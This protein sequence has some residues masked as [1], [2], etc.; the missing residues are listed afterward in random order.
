MKKYEEAI[1]SLPQKGDLVFVKEE[2]ELFLGPEG[3]KDPGQAEQHVLKAAWLCLL[4][5]SKSAEF[6]PKVF[7]ALKTTDYSKLDLFQKA[8]IH[9]L[10]FCQYKDGFFDVQ[11]AEIDWNSGADN[12]NKTIR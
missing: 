2:L 12:W 6:G 5:W 8:V 3:E 10:A 4:E 9:I 11:N 7:E 1:N